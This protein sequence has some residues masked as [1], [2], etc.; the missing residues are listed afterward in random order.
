MEAKQKKILTGLFFGSFNPVHTGHL[1]IASYLLQNTPLDRIWF[2]VSPLNPLKDQKDLFDQ[3]TRLELV[4]LAIAGNPGFELCLRELSMETPSYT[5][6]TI[7]VLQQENPD[8]EFVL[9]IGSDNLKVFD[10]W[11]NYERILEMLPVMVY[12][13]QGRCR[14]PF[15]KHPGVSLVKAPLLE[16]SSTFIRH[17]LNQGKDI[18]YMVPEAVY[19]KIQEGILK[20]S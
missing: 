15:L 10:K 3:H 12:P 9:I 5:Y 4:R 17:S 8:H 7:E 6:K 16:I 14:S 13:R 20:R 11:K 1:I 19:N 18:R 2:V